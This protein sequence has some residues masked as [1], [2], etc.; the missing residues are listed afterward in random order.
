MSLRRSVKSSVARQR[1]LDASPVARTGP[2]NTAADDFMPVPIG[3][4]SRFKFAE[5]GKA[6]R[7]PCRKAS[8]ALCCLILDMLLQVFAS[9]S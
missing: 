9:S 8:P 5:L 2:D 1:G 4:R 7:H 6:I 3:M